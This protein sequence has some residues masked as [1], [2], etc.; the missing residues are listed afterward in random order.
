MADV[1]EYDEDES[2]EEDMDD[3]DGL[4]CDFKYQYACSWPHPMGLFRRD[5]SKGFKPPLSL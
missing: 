5:S 4:V 1:M 2:D 3:Y